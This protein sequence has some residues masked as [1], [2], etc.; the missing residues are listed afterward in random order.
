MNAITRFDWTAE[1]VEILLAGYNDG[2]SMNRIA[3]LLGGGV[4]RN[5]VVGKLHRMHYHRGRVVA[6]PK[7]PR[8]PPKGRR[9]SVKL[10]YKD[11]A[12]ERDSTIIRDDLRDLPPDQ[13]PD[14]VALLDAVDGQCRWPLNDPGPGFLFCGS[15]TMTDGCSWCARHARMAFTPA[16]ELKPHIPARGARV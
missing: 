14:A 9:H 1:K 6:G 13:S 2:S 5:A 12:F 8:N 11:G 10:T 3:G 4:T 7:K 15:D 16:R